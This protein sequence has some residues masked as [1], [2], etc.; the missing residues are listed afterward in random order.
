MCSTAWPARSRC[1]ATHSESAPL[2]VTARQRR[3]LE[4][5]RAGASN[6][7][8]AVQVGYS[9]KTI[10]NDLTALYRLLGATSRADLV[11]RAFDVD[12]DTDL[13]PGTETG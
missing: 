4:L 5:V 8:I 1:R 7:Q 13:A 3:V 12:P 6:G 10:K 2:A 9:E 11:A